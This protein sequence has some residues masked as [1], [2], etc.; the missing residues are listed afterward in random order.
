[1]RSVWKSS[2]FWLLLIFG[3]ALFIRLIWLETLPATFFV[4]EVLSGYMGRF[5]LINHMD[6]FGNPDPWLYFNKFGD[7][8][9]L[10]RKIFLLIMLPNLS[11]NYGLSR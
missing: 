8:Y 1:M 3:L 10:P 2:Y 6:L 5:M 9:I 11:P 4:D 7:Y